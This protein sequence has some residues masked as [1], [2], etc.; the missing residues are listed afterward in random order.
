MGDTEAKHL[1]REHLAG[2]RP[3]HVTNA[4]LTSV[5]QPV[6]DHIVFRVICIIEHAYVGAWGKK[7][8]MLQCTLWVEVQASLLLISATRLY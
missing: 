8:Q 2:L 4:L 1:Q 5:C 3:S 7:S 6:L